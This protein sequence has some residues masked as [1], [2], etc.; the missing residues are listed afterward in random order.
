MRGSV[1]RVIEL[2]GSKEA[3]CT[4]EWCRPVPTFA[5]VML[6]V[7]LGGWAQGDRAAGQQRSRLHRCAGGWCSAA[8]AAGRRCGQGKRGRRGSVPCGWL[9]DPPPTPDLPP[10]GKLHHGAAFCGLSP[11][12]DADLPRTIAP[13]LPSLPAGKFHYGT[14]FGEPAGL[15]DTVDHISQAG[16]GRGRAGCSWARGCR[17]GSGWPQVCV[18]CRRS[19]PLARAGRPPPCPARPAALRPLV[20]PDSRPR[21]SNQI[22]ECLQE[23]VESGFSYSG[24]DLIH[25]GITGARYRGLGRALGG[26]T[27]GGSSAARAATSACGQQTTRQ[28]HAIRPA[29]AGE[30]PR[31]PPPLLLAA[32]ADLALLRPPATCPC[33]RG[34]GGLHLHGARLLPEAEAHGG[35]AAQRWQ[36][37]QWR[38]GG[39]AC[40]SAGCGVCLRRL[41]QSPEAGAHCGW[42]WAVQLVWLALP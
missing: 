9:A 33:R 16:G 3:V 30:A 28:L 24:K 27:A 39:L 32:A 25:S 12:P 1:G 19:S 36:R 13:S 4:G 21:P 14:A 18:A 31:G 17:A 42:L 6:R 38:A 26:S 10:A 5:E 11:V 20:G 29:A 7:Q 41:E 34:A 23:L 15:A 2:P 8:G 35:W 40:L 37:W 22:L